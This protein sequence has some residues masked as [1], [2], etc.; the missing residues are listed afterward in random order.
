MLASLVLVASIA[1][2]TMRFDDA[3]ALADRHESALTEEQG[4]RLGA[5]LSGV[6]R[7]AFRACMPSP[8]P[9]T[10]PSFTIFMKLDAMGK[11]Q[12]T[13]HENATVFTACVEKAFR[14]AT[15]FTPPTSPFYTS[16]EFVFGDEP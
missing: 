13:W 11:V 16:F 9:E 1:A 14:D 10:V 15:L 12:A 5:S 8:L 2:D 3:K 7:A 4:E 6:G